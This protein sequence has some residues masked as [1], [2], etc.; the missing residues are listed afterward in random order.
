MVSIIMV[1][2]IMIVGKHHDDGDD[3]LSLSM[4]IPPINHSLC[5]YSFIIWDDDRYCIGSHSLLVR[6]DQS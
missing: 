3:D 2:S 5:M 4:L 6:R 1:L